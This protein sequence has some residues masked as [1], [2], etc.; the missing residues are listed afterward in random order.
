MNIARLIGP[1]LIA[2]AFLAAHPA[3]AQDRRAEEAKAK[4][5]IDAWRGEMIKAAKDEIGPARRKKMQ[6]L[7]DTL[8]QQLSSVKC[9][10]SFWTSGALR[11]DDIVDDLE[12]SIKIWKLPI[13]LEYKPTCTGGKLQGKIEKLQV[14]QQLDDED[15]AADGAEKSAG[16]VSQAISEW[17][18][19]V[20][21]AADEIGQPRELKTKLQQIGHKYEDKINKIACNPKAKTKFDFKARL[22]EE[23]KK[24]GMPKGMSGSGICGDNVWQVVLLAPTTIDQDP[25]DMEKGASAAAKKT[26][27]SIAPA[28]FPSP[29]SFTNDTQKT[30]YVA[31]FGP[32]GE[33]AKKMSAI[34]CKPNDK[35][36]E[37]LYNEI[38]EKKKALWDIFTYGGGDA[39]TCKD[40]H[41][42][43][44]LTAGLNKSA[45]TSKSGTNGGNTKDAKAGSSAKPG[46]T[47]A[48]TGK[49]DNKKSSH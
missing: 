45:S 27:L 20:R 34:E 43:L 41:I 6:D 38:S 35:T 44:G 1:T 40:G 42:A 11:P 18:A 48:N 23:K 30:A 10:D 7:T 28:M 46:T 47:G 5:F 29:K 22:E 36:T 39:V 49:K 37:Y 9:D 2:A 16:A 14:A 17:G 13:T 8:S 26:W 33:F 4:T 32:K 25:K 3:Q 19:E 31:K 15:K 24:A 12:R 21:K